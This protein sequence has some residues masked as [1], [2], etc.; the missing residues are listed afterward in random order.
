MNIEVN[1]LAVLLAAVASMA[2]G[3]F[4]YS[5]AFLG[6]PWMK[7]KG[8]TK[9]SLKQAQQEMG[10]LYALS[11][12]AALFTA[13]ILSHII[14]LSQSFY[15]NPVVATGITTAFFAWIGFVMP[16]Q[17]TATIF[18]DKKW[19]LLAIDTGY[20]LAALMTMSLVLAYFA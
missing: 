9:A 15:G 4:W 7:L 8:Y 20:Q 17:F 12:V 19:K 3:F 16:V 14:T 2:L 1:Y 6:K 5:P 11:F 18:G 13:Y 10:K